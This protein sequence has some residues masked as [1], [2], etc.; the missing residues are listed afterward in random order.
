VNLTG[1]APQAL[2][3]IA[4]ISALS[5]CHF[6]VIRSLGSSQHVKSATIMAFLVLVWFLV[7][8]V[9]IRLTQDTTK[10]VIRSERT[11][12]VSTSLR[13]AKGPT[14]DRVH[15]VRAFPSLTFENL[16]NLVQPDDGTD[17]IF[18]T[19]QDGRV[20]YFLNQSTANEAKEYLNISDRVSISRPEEGL[21]GLVFD[22]A[23]SDNG[24]FYV[25]Y[26]QADPRRSVVSRFQR[27]GADPEVADPETELIILEIAQPTGQHNGGQLAFGPDGFLYIGVGDGGAAVIDSP[28]QDTASLLGSILRIDVKASSPERPYLVPPDNPFVGSPNARDEIWAYGLRNP[29]RFS[30]DEQ[31]G[32]LWVPDVG[33]LL[34]E[35]INIVEKGKNYGWN[36]MEGRS[37][38]RQ[39]NCHRADLELPLWQYPRDGGRCAVIGGYVYRGQEFPILTGAYIFADLCSGILS[40]L[41]LEGGA[42]TEEIELGLAKGGEVTAGETEMLGL[43]TRSFGQDLAGNLYTLDQSG[44]IFRLAL[45]LATVKGAD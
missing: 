8:V 26:S 10:G 3:A 20:F 42:V 31:T 38:I 36:I 41:R 11:A 16:T 45:A 21:L 40:A 28:S 27:S 4:A 30:F 13:I 17:R 44:K 1:I 22:P 37:C 7:L 25:H 39:V 32:L 34:R 19:E 29:W 15:V 12:P 24:F 6:F 35:E 43:F 9:G 18:I 23:F 5:A 33:S 2:G 14:A